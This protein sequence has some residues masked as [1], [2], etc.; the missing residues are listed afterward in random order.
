MFDIGPF[1][2]DIGYDE[3]PT[4][5]A[6]RT[7]RLPDNDRMV[8]TLGH[9]LERDRSVQRRRVHMRVEIDSPT[10]DTHSSSSSSLVGSFDGHAD[11]V[12]VSAQYRFIK[13]EAAEA[14]KVDEGTPPGAGF[15]LYDA[16]V[17]QT[18][19]Q[20]GKELREYRE[21]WIRLKMLP[22]SEELT[23]TA[24][25]AGTSEGKYEQVD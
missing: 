19:K 2:G 16:A 5:A 12:G 22:M 4:N 11:L 8:Y 18:C 20:G 15:L 3:T 1:R 9:D 17:P 14:A 24:H 23:V 10:A 25:C 7:P 6:H 13:V 21:E